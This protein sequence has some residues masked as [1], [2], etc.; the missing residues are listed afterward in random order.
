[1]TTIGLLIVL[2]SPSDDDGNDE[3]EDGHDDA[4]DKGVGVDVD[5][6]GNISDASARITYGSGCVS[7][8]FCGT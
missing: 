7:F 3:R 2:F 4:G 6:G 1:M 5:D 8:F